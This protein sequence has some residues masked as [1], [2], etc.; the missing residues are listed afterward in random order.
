MNK[1][2]RLGLP[3]E[4][5]PTQEV[6]PPCVKPASL[7]LAPWQLLHLFELQLYRYCCICFS[8]S[9][10]TTVAS[11]CAA[12]AGY[13]HTMLQNADPHTPSLALPA[14]FH[15]CLDTFGLYDV[16]NHCMHALASYLA[17]MQ[18]PVQAATSHHILQDPPL[19][20]AFHVNTPHALLANTAAS[21]YQPARHRSCTCV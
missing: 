6:H 16:T 5:K 9:C 20:H 7:F 21:L 14:M 10:M 8:S 1:R 12:A 13:A 15:S 18:A 2:Q 17:V 19:A 3:M 11:V 4:R